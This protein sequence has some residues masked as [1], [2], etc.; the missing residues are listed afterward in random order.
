MD[1]NFFGHKFMHS[2]LASLFVIYILQPTINRGLVSWNVWQLNFSNKLNDLMYQNAALGIRN[3][4][5]VLLF[6]IF[7]VLLMSIILGQLLIRIIV[8]IIKATKKT[9]I[10]L[11]IIDSKIAKIIDAEEH[12]VKLP[13]KLSF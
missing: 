13:K 12:K 7:L 9:D 8:N 1:K 2:V 10:V 3:W 4:V 5:D 6:D 11:R